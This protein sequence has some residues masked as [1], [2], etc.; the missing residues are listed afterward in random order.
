MIRPIGLLHCVV[1][2][3]IVDRVLR[4]VNVALRVV[5]VLR[6]MA[7]AVRSR[8]VAMRRAV[9]AVIAGRVLRLVIAALRVVIVLREMASVDRL[10]RVAMCRVVRAAIAGR[11]LRLV[12]VALHVA[13]VL[14]AMASAG[15][16]HLVAMRHEVRA[17]IVG[18][19]LR[20]AI[21]A[22]RVATVLRA[23][24]SAVR[25]ALATTHRVVRTVTARPARHSTTVVVSAARAPIADHVH[26]S[27][28]GALHVAIVPSAEASDARSSLAKI[29]AARA[30]IARRDPHSTTMAHHAA[31]ATTRTTAARVRP[32]STASVPQAIGRLQNARHR[33]NAL[34]TSA[35]QYA[36]RQ[37]NPR[38]RATPTHHP[39]RHA[40]HA[41]VKTG[42]CDCRR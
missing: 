6:E 29:L 32:P 21:V 33:R 19:V 17:V 4:L 18:R 20:L 5:I 25:S 10:R 42:S 9:R 30:A 35:S 40:S 24:A 26:L 13:T 16:S 14:R 23:T 15:R 27:A 8:R 38:N 34:A 12:I 3:G 11:V 41:K 22:R 36:S 28:T 37:Q 2:A 31:S 39:L 7:S 1:P